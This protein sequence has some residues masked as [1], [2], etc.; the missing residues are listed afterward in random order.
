MSDKTAEKPMNKTE[1]IELRRVVKNRFELLQ[2]QLRERAKEVR[3]ILRHEIEKD[4]KDPLDEAK[5]RSANL[6]RRAKS[7]VEDTI[8]LHHEMEAQGVRADYS[9]VEGRRREMSSEMNNIISYYFEGW[10][11]INIEK[12][13]E[14]K[15]AELK[16]MQGNATLNLRHQEISILEDLAVGGLVS[17]EARA[18]LDKVPGV[19]DYMPL[20]SGDALKAL[21]A[22][23]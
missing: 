23:S 19:D 14:E 12:M 20:P 18:Y 2:D 15:Q 17:E 21:T 7:L 6:K 3:S 1:R 8:K 10:E 16:K 13:V 22:G 4:Y 5:H 11:P 9:L